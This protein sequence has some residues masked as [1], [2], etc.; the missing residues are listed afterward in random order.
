M[1][2]N[3]L[4]LA[5]IGVILP[6]IFVC[7]VMLET[8]NI[9]LW[10]DIPTTFNSMFA[11]D[12]STTFMIDLLFIVLLFMAW[13]FQQSRKHRIKNL[14]AFWLFTFAFG[15]AGGLPLFLYFRQKQLDAKEAAAL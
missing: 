5:I 11:N 13:S 9:L 1:K 4:I 7:K 15:I 10:T 2:R 8:G 14:W 12:I 6:N 3:Y